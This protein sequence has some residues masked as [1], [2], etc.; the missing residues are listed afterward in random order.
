MLYVNKIVE[1]LSS[2]D[3]HCDSS[4]ESRSL[5]NNVR[6]NGRIC[7]HQ[8]VGAGCLNNSLWLLVSQ[9]K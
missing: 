3:K 7:T 8:M 9:I 2:V 6:K 5:P 1:E 4:N